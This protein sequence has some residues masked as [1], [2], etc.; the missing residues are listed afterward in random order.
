MLEISDKHTAETILFRN[1]LD[2]YCLML[3]V[4]DQILP[5]LKLLT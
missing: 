4:L 3:I 5:R 1:V 2:F